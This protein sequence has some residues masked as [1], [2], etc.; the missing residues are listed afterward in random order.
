M[1]I[2]PFKELMSLPGISRKLLF[3]EITEH[4]TFALFSGY[5]KSL[6]K[7]FDSNIVGGPSIVF[8]RYH[9][10]DKTAIRS[11]IYNDAK[12]CKIIKGWDCNR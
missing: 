8:C 3:R 4:N 5:T 10:V 2:D 7:L 12:P 6:Y 11:H 1:N 9:E